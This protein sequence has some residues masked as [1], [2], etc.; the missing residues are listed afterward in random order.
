MI[1]LIGLGNPGEEYLQTRHNI[2]FRV[3]DSL[4]VRLKAEF[5]SGLG[6]YII[7]PG[8]YRDRHLLLVKPTTYVNKSGVAV[9]RLLFLFPLEL[10]RLLVVCD[11]VN[12]PLGRIR[13]RVRGSD[14]GHKGLASIIYHLGEGGFPR[15]RIGIGGGERDDL[16]DFVLGEFTP[17]EKVVMERVIEQAA[18]ACLC[19][20]E[21]GI[22]EVMNRYNKRLEV[23]KP[24]NPKEKI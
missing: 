1:A 13:I 8:K 21:E 17:A 7:A 3:I 24:T 22:E 19:F 14:G 12:L 20:L 11:D 4:A 6:E 10:S 16:V 18:E 23:E 2:G 15:L 5:R 9:S